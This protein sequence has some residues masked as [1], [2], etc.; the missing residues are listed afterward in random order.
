MGFRIDTKQAASLPLLERGRVDGLSLAV[1]PALS[2]AYHPD[3]M[4]RRFLLCL[5]FLSG[6]SGLIYQIAWVRQASLTFGVSVYAFSAVLTAYLGGLALGS[7][8]FGRR[9]DRSIRPLRLYAWLEIG[10]AALAVVVSF[11]LTGLNNVYALAA[12]TLHPG[13]ELLTLLRLVLSI[14]VIAPAA[15]LIGG[16]LP[17]MS[18]I[19]AARA[20][21]VGRDVGQ[22]Y[23][24]NTA[25]AVLGC[26]LTPL[27]L[28]RLFG[29]REA[30]FI[31]AGLNGSVAVGVLWL[32]RAWQ[33][34][35]ATSTRRRPVRQPPPL[36]A[37]PLPAR[38][39]HYLA[40][41][42]A[43]AG[44]AAL[45]YEVIWAR[46]L[47]I[48]TLNAVYSF[49]L[50]LTV[51]LTGLAVGGGLGS[52]RLRRHQATLLQF[53]LLQ[54]G[55]GLLAMLALFIFARLPS[56]PFEAIFSQYTIGREI[57][58]EL[59]LAF[60]TLFPPT[61][62][63]GLTFPVVSSLYTREQADRVG[64]HI[65]QVSA[66]NTLGSISGA[67]LTG[68]VLIP[69]LGLRNASLTLSGL[70]LAVGMGAVWLSS[71][72]KPQAQWLPPSAIALAVVATLAMP[73][74]LY[75]GFREGT[76][77]HLVFY[78]EGVETTVAV[79]DVAEQNFKVSFVNGRSEVPTDE[80]SLRAFRLLGHLPALLQP[81]A[82][83]ALVLSFG[84]GI[85]TG[86][87]D[88]HFIPTIDAV[89]LSEEMI[90]AASI[91]WQENYNILQSAHL[92]LHVEDARNFLLQTGEPY[93]IITTDATHPTNASSWALFT[94][95][96]YALVRRRLTPE[97]VFAQWLPFHSLLEEDYKAIIRTALS[98]F[99]HVSLWYTGGSHTFLVATPEPLTEEALV[100][101]LARVN[102]NPTVLNDLGSPGVVRG[103]LA[104]DEMALAEYAGAGRLVTDNNA[105]FFSTN[106]ETE[107]ILGFMQALVRK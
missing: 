42:Y 48:H 27:L 22:L 47:S 21:R 43:L 71:G 37:K 75:L 62:L 3:T 72:A 96:F 4:Q 85:A 5:F 69:L 13:P 54:L 6:V 94:Q 61:L 1:L 18:R 59:L 76:S 58:Y 60:I 91:Y 36:T 86:S 63:M 8:L 20:G 9:I 32:E 33:P 77:E 51:F 29:A 101:L 64:L 103:Y 68:F 81:E 28:M 15:L 95:E 93:D 44:L 82:D 90:E 79:F 106:V 17:V 31:G 14:L 49:A 107:K 34:D 105:F 78:K 87:L 67:L 46:I 11:S 98:V 40:G 41:G 66:L 99:P 57:L 80:T 92:K 26:L 45:G 83:N 56:L 73:P 84:N 102:E 10:I 12:Q 7:Y 89:D 16:T 38:T 53:G 104:M 39:L 23:T 35:T 100:A 2:C 55:I 88:T 70:N 74:G 50:M 52:W 19:Y 24:A 97:G 65:G 30:I 25:G